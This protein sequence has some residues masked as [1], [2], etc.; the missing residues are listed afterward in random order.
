[1]NAA[2]IERKVVAE[3]PDGV[4]YADAQGVIRYW[5]GGCTRIFGY[6]AHERLASLWTSS[7][8]SS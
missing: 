8:P 3:T 4:L 1:M 2:D 6:N 5:N 7:S